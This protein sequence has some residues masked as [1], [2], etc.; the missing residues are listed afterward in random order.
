MF[1]TAAKV[2]CAKDVFFDH[3][4]IQFLFRETHVV[5]EANVKLWLLDYFTHLISNR[6]KSLVTEYCSPPAK[7]A[8]MVVKMLLRERRPMIS[9]WQIGAPCSR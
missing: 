2:D 1:F 3:E 7:Y 8:A 5:E 6:A 9:V 4:N